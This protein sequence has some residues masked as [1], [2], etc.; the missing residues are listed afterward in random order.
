[1]ES[2]G[3]AIEAESTVTVAFP[4]EIFQE[5]RRIAAE[6]N[7]PESKVILLAKLG[8]KA[9]KRAGQSLQSTHR[10]FM[11]ES[12]PSTQGERGDDI[13]PPIFGPAAIR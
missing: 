1:M 11:D 10:A 6:E 5:I 8:V 3:M 7:W 9:Q 13:I 4:L 2:A 12:A